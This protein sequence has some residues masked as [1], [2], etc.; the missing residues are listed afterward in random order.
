MTTATLEH[1][2]ARRPNPGPAVQ[3]TLIA[4][5]LLPMLGGATI[6]PALPEIRDVFAGTPN[7]PLLTGMV[8]STHALALMLLSPLAGWLGDSTG[9]KPTLLAG[10]AGFALAGTSGAW[11]PDLPSILV[12]RLV[13]GASIALLM[14]SMTGLVGDL[15]DEESRRRLLSRQ[16][17]AGTGGG[18]LFML[19]A[20]ALAT[21][22]WREA[23]LM[24]LV[25]AVVLL[26]A[27]LFV[28]SP[29]APATTA[30]RGPTSNDRLGLWM[31]APVAAM[32]LVQAIFYV[33]PTQIP[34]LFA[35][36]FGA[37]P[38][39]ISAA[40]SFMM[41]TM[42][43]VSLLYPRLS[44]QA[45]GPA[46]VAAAFTAP[47]AGF[48]VLAVADARWTIVAGLTIIAAGMALAM[49][50]LN[51]WIISSTRD[52]VRG[53]AVGMLTTALFAGQFLSPVLTQP[54]INAVGLRAVFSGL[55]VISAVTALGYAT[56]ARHR[57]QGLNH[58]PPPARSV[59]DAGFSARHS[60]A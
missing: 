22:G 47:A 21:V 33:V 51:N 59:R 50:N 55:A 6:A 52:E 3:A 44:R 15:F 1:P 38:F 26:P 32:F 2:L 12:G 48:V 10:L 30:G 16:Q 23:F 54:V 27:L 13:L 35:R 7:A 29:R 4:A 18:L 25:G 24:Y 46:L 53:R 57:K 42:L 37:G 40:L 60:S 14:T 20:G 41:L 11:L 17:A 28:P 43:P 19:G 5:A 8:L 34:G 31:V 39:Q 49:P 58:S 36:D 9:R 56:L 45:S